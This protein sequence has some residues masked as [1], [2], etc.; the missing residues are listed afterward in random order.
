MHSWKLPWYR[1]PQFELIKFKPVEFFPPKPDFKTLQ[2][3]CIGSKS[4]TIGDPL[5]LSTL[6]EKL[7]KQY[8]DLKVFV[9]PRSFNPVVFWNNPYVDGVSFLPPAL[10]GDDCNE[11]KG[12][13]IQLKER[14]FGLPVSET[15]RPS[16]FLTEREKARAHAWLS[17]AESKARIESRRTGLPLLI[18]HPFGRTRDNVLS[19]EAWNA[20]LPELSKK[21]RICQIGIE[22]H[23]K[24]S[25]CDFHFFTGRA[26]RHARDLFAIIA[27]GQNFVGVDS[28]PMHIARAFGLKSTVIVGHFDVE[29]S[30]DHPQS[31]FLYLGDLGVTHIAPE[32]AN[33]RLLLDLFE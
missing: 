32:R 12:Q 27:E 15:P 22:G 19:P 21:F 30:P 3:I 33:A 29:N 25:G 8:P 10:Y 2:S 31:A 14:F 13:L 9:Y 1:Y 7:K 26:R 16:L 23:P 5:M 28:G 6:P 20:M 18:L 4:R 11:G 24:L 17:D